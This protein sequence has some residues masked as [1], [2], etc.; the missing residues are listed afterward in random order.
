MRRLHFSP[1]ILL[2]PLLAAAFE[3]LDFQGAVLDEQTVELRWLLD[4][5]EGV[6]GFEVERSTDDEHFQ[7]IGNRIQA[8]SAVE[9]SLIDQ[10][11][12]SATGG[13]GQMIDMEQ[14][15]YY[16]LYYI[17]PDQ[18]RLSAHDRSVEVSFQMSTVSVTWGS[19]KAMFR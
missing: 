3:L 15:Y 14:T 2:L 6:S 5:I 7:L 10:P 13:R 8:S 11:G 18:S 19:I 4:R 16:R 12:L 1:L 9:Y 17:L